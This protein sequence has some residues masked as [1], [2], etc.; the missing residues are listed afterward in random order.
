MIHN[1]LRHFIIT[2]FVPQNEYSTKINSSL[3]VQ[4]F[5][6]YSNFMNFMHT[7]LDDFKAQF[8]FLVFGQ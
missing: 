6:D 3:G 5:F 4:G 2:D 1:Q 8:F 7:D